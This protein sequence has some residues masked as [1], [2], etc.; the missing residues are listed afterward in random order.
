[1]LTTLMAGVSVPAIMYLIFVLIQIDEQLKT[2]RE[3]TPSFLYSCRTFNA[4][5]T[6]SKER[7]LRR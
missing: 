3:G 7:Q 4:I 5:L 2:G 1:M 6:T